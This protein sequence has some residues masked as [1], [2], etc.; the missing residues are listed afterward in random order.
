MSTLQ[1]AVLDAAMR[2]IKLRNAP[3]PKEGQSEHANAVY[4]A[5]DELDAACK[6]LEANEPGS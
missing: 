5:Q 6:A 2:Y 3:Y 4:A 1:K